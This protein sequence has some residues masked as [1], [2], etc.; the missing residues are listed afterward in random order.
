MGLAWM[1]AAALSGCTALPGPASRPLPSAADP[2]GVQ[3]APPVQ[4][5]ERPPQTPPGMG[6]GES[7]SGQGSAAGPDSRDLHALMAEL[8]ELGALDPDAQQLIM[9]DLRQTEPA[10]WKPVMERFRTALAYRRRMEERRRADRETEAEQEEPAGE[11]IGNRASPPAGQTASKAAGEARAEG[12][13]AGGAEA[14]GPPSDKAQSGK[15]QSGGPAGGGEAPPAPAPPNQAVQ[16]D[17]AVTP[18]S[19]A[20]PAAAPWQDRLAGA[21]RGLEAEVSPAPKT[22]EEIARH[23]CL[24]LLYLAAGR[25]EEA[26]RPIPGVP[27]AMQD[28]WSTEVYGLQTLLDDQRIADRR[29]RAAEAKRLLGEAAAKLSAA[30]PLAIRGLAFASEVQS[31]GCYVKFEKDEFAPGQE[32]L[33]YAEVENFKSES[34]PQGFHTSLRSSYKLFDGRGQQVA[35]QEFP[36]TEEHCRSPRRDFFIGYHLRLPKDLYPGKHTLKLTLE[37]L[38]RGEVCQASIEFSVRPGKE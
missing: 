9:E 30:A 32:V 23:A 24:R 18:A 19:H 21:I 27:P 11:E 10:M 17:P 8:Q 37:D 2:P 35:E 12:P 34:T 14:G 1:L 38:K 7:S 16:A 29:D 33:L 36:V 28:F 31:F 22:D 6:A 3:A 4:P 13:Q 15:A 5:Q 25:R 26:M 20:V